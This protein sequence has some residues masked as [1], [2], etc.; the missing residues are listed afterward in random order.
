M[1]QNLNYIPS[2]RSIKDYKLNRLVPTLESFPTEFRISYDGV[3]KNQGNIGSCA[4]H[5]LS[6][7]REVMEAKQSNSFKVFSTD[8]VYGNRRSTDYAGEGMMI[9]EGAQILLD[10]GDVYKELLSTNSTFPVAKQLVN[11]NRA[12]LDKNAYEHRITAFATA[13]NADEIKSALMQLGPVVFGIT[14]YDNFYDVKS[15]GIVSLPTNIS[16]VEGGHCMLIVGWKVINNKE[17]W[18]VLNSWSEY[19]G[20]KGY[21]YLPFDYDISEAYAI[22]DDVLP[23]PVCKA[24]NIAVDGVRAVGNKLTV[25]YKYSHPQDIPEGDTEI[26]WIKDCD[27]VA[28]GKEYLLT[29]NDATKN[30]T[31]EIHPK[32]QNGVY[33]DADAID[34]GVIITKNNAPVL[35]NVML[36]GTALSG[37]TMTAKYDYH[38]A[39]GDVEGCTLIEWFLDAN[40]LYDAS[41]GIPV[42]GKSVMIK[43]NYA[44]NSIYAKITPVDAKG[45]K[46]TTYTTPAYYIYRS[47]VPPIANFTL[48]K[49]VANIGDKILVTN[50]SKDNN[51]D[52][53]LKYD[54]GEYNNQ[55]TKTNSI[56]F[57]KAGTFSITLTVTDSYGAKSSLTK[58]VVIKDNSVTTKKYYRVQ[59]GAFKSKEN[60]KAQLDALTQLGYKPYITLVN[61][62]YKVQIGAFSLRE[63][64]NALALKLAAEGAMVV[65]Y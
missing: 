2:G 47:N 27:V 50:M 32:D 36:V 34:T 40:Q 30:L 5:S 4:A 19:W 26:L 14:V 58:Q 65:Y 35:T 15:D 9:R 25:S 17:Y 41:T 3:V 60:A 49:E 1:Q 12:E 45:L 52:I 61:S 48:S 37:C 64:A 38:D 51:N 33:G 55:I 8:Y 59:V 22:T 31:V 63:N 11:A 57:T 10:F 42:I 7:Q 46:G 23:M 16:K 6:E 54:W 28:E 39:D 21:C 56:I 53:V 24:D 13:E 29:E 43:D 20:D 18:V 44:N 62:L